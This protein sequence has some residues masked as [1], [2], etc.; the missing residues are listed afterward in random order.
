MRIALAQINPTVGDIETNAVLI[1]KDIQRAAEAGAAMVVF[2]E[3]SILGYPPR[4]L[5]LKPAVIQ[6]CQQAVEE[7]AELCDGIAAVLGYPCPSDRDAGRMLYNAAAF[8]HDGK[9]AHRHVKSL[10]PTYDVFDETRYFEPGPEVD[11]IA[12]DGVTLG[13]SICEDLWNDQAIFARRLYHDNPIHKLAKRGAQLFVNSAA[14]PFVMDKHPFRLRLMSQVTRTYGL[15]LVYCNQ[16]GGNDELVF[17]GASCMFDAQGRVVAHAKSFE[18]DLLVA[19]LPLGDEASNAETRESTSPQTANAAPQVFM[20]APVSRDHPMVQSLPDADDTDAAAPPREGEQTD[21]TSPQIELATV[22][23]RV[24]PYPQNIAAAYHALVLGLGDYCRKCGFNATVLGLSGGIDSAVTAALCVAA[25]GS[26]KVRGVSMPSRYSSE[27]SKTDAQVLAERLH[28]RFHTIPIADV[29]AS[30]ESLL[31]P[32][33]EGLEPDTT[34]ENLQA[35]ARGVILMALSNKFRSLLV[36]TGNKSELAVGYCTLYG[37]MAGGLAAL[38][39]V[40][41]TDVYRLAQWINSPQCPLY[42]Q[43]DGPV[44]PEDTITKPPSAELRPDQTDQDS[45]PPYDVLDEIIERY[46][47]LE[48]S[49]RQ[50]IAQTGFDTAT[51]LRVVRMIDLNEYKRQQAAPGLKITGRAFGIGRRMPIAQR[52]DNRRGVAQSEAGQG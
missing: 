16:V 17:D 44:I 3:L 39:D 6:E 46:V 10:L 41:K 34:E 48:Q 36:T 50:I 15:P 40:P 47:E 45:L 25:L 12:F 21:E 22:H 43:F 13:V 19:D 2:P 30:F 4:D 24:E 49:A 1:R 14:S 29:H 52:Y 26:D 7:L 35:R 51:V 9:L 33:F 20:T 5:L 18:P 42:Q 37:D 8:C 27:G 11:V 31:T 38:S 28:M 32:H 23:G